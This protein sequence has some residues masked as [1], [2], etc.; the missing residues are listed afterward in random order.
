MG[1]PPKRIGSF[2]PGGPARFSVT[3]AFSTWSLP[4]ESTGG[5]S[6]GPSDWA[7]TMIGPG[8]L[9]DGAALATETTSS[10]TLG[11]GRRGQRTESILSQ[12]GSRERHPIRGISS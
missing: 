9:G 12:T 7:G 3:S 11:R 6:N 1:R 4:L 8:P 5:W 10:S 2:E